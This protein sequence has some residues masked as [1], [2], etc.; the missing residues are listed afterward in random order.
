M[1]VPQYVDSCPAVCPDKQGVDDVAASSAKRSI[2]V[3]MA[4]IRD[5]KGSAIWATVPR[6]VHDGTGV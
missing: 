5:A 6:R 4:N 1:A 2:V 3:Y